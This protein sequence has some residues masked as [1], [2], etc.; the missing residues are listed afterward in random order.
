MD[1]Q[2]INYLAEVSIYL[3]VSWL[4]YRFLLARFTFFSLNRFFLLFALVGSLI[5]PFIP[6]LFEIQIDTVAVPP[7]KQWIS[8]EALKDLAAFN[9]V[10]DEVINPVTKITMNYESRL[11]IIFLMGVFL[12]SVRFIWIL[13][14]SVKII[15]NAKKEKIGEFTIYFHSA[16]KEP[17]SLFSVILLPFDWKKAPKN[18][19][20][21]ILIHEKAHVKQKH[22]LDLLIAELVITC[23]WFLPIAYYLKKSIRIN[24][25][26]LADQTVLK[27]SS[28][29]QYQYHLLNEVQPKF[30]L[31]L[32]QPFYSTPIKT[33]F[34]MMKKT[35]TS[36][37]KKV[38]YIMLLSAFILPTIALMPAKN[39]AYEKLEVAPA[40]PSN[41]KQLIPFFDEKEFYPDYFPVEK[42]K[43]YRLSSSFGMR[44]HP[45]KKIKQLH[46][47]VDFSAPAGA[48]VYA[49]AAGTVKIAKNSGKQGYG[50]QVDIQ[51][52]ETSYLTR[53]AQLNEYIV[54]VGQFV[55]KGEVIG[56]IGSSG[57]STRPH[58]H[59][60]I[61]QNDKAVDPSKY[62]AINDLE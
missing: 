16:V 59:F 22:W 52:G 3:T 30:D 12:F 41:I 37:W 54:E 20:T 36:T 1:N 24:L 51:H 19:S 50:I 18:I 35:P 29:E 10:N 48:K 46:M 26:F 58:L 34:K 62:I 45:I 42:E 33:R 55:K 43:V 40:I 28:V 11:Q 49:A 13:A 31:A 47:G 2:L 38:V 44:I 27:Y 39:M 61:R 25:E 56:Y 17:C 4:I 9:T 8:K 7:A 32:A 53:Y 15:F 57:L 5:L 6:N 14:N 60:E 23:F 21:E